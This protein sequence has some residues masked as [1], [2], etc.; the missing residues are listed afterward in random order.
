MF[1]NMIEL[2]I[3]L[4]TQPVQ[5][6]KI[7]RTSEDISKFDG[8]SGAELLDS[9]F[10]S[11]GLSQNN[12]ELSICARDQYHHF[13]ITYESTLLFLAPTG[14]QGVKMLCVCAHDIPQIMRCSSIL[15]SPGAY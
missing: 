1:Y 12:H 15:K 11:L 5:S 10:D 13:N 6:I 2:F 9:S 8:Q 4:F 3:L 14:A 7:V